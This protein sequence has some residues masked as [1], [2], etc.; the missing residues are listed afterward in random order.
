M[1]HRET[2]ERSAKGTRAPYAANSLPLTSGGV[3]R[4]VEGIAIRIHASCD[5]FR[6]RDQLRPQQAP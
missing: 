6:L 1:L 2:V 3:E 5:A 4:S